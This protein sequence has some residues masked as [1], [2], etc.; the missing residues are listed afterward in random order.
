MKKKLLT[1]FAMFVV[2]SAVASAKDLL[3]VD[4]DGVGIQGYDPV[5]FF[6]DGRPVKGYAQFQS[7]YHGAKYYFASSEHK[8]AFDKEPAK[9]EPQF[10][11]YCAY[12]VSHGSRAPVKV[13]ASQIVNGRLLMQYDLDVK[14]S[15]NKDTQG[16]LKKADQNWPGLVEKYGK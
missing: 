10:G 1:T 11:G 2:L 15:F 14:D 6:S 8:A 4:R 12:G 7:Q 9:Y 13:E 3:N 16:S 5:A